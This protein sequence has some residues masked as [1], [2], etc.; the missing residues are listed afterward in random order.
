MAGPDPT[1][2]DAAR[3]SPGERAPAPILRGAQVVLRPVADTDVPALEAILRE[4]EVKRWW[5]RDTWDR[6]DEEGSTVF[7]MLVD[8]EVAGCIEY[9]EETDPDYRHAGVDLFVAG[10]FQG[11]GVGT[12]ALRTVLAYL[13]DELGHHRVIIDPAVENERAVHVY[14]KLGFRRVGVMRRYERGADG[15]WHDGLLMELLAEELV[16]A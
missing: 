2:A 1:A 12:D 9:A 15:E 13:I 7:V 14:E 4:P 10:R 3:P 11:Q 16:R 6:V 8:G 5:M